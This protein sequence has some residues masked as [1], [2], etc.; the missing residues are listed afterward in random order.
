MLLLA[1]LRSRYPRFGFAGRVPYAP[2]QRRQSK[3][4]LLFFV[5]YRRYVE[6]LILLV[7]PPLFILIREFD[8]HIEHWD[9][10]ENCFV[11]AERYIWWLRDYLAIISFM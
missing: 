1:T 7:T 6:C 4:C 3:G 8:S 2:H 10:I 5:F 11:I 9:N